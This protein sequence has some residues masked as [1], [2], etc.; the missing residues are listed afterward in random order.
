[1]KLINELL[2]HEMAYKGFI[3]WM[4]AV[5]K[6]GLKLIIKG[7]YD[8]EAQDEKSKRTVGH[9]KVDFQNGKI[10]ADLAEAVGDGSVGDWFDKQLG[11]LAGLLMKHTLAPHELEDA[12]RQI[13]SVLSG[14]IKRW[15]NKKALIVKSQAAIMDANRSNDPARTVELLKQLRAKLP[16]ERDK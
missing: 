4:Q 7:D 13:A 2:L 6:L 5:K 10:M 9:F 3:D 16:P 12:E 14:W 11:K 8:L 15:P 1:M